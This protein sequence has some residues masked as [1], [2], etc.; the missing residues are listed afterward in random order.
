MVEWWSD[1]KGSTL[2]VASSMLGGLR[3]GRLLI[4]K[5]RNTTAANKN[6]ARL[7]TERDFYFNHFSAVKSR[8]L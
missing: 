6:P 3:I 5:R 8:K 2:D 4:G 7:F 1:G